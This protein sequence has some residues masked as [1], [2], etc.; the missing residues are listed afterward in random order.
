[1]KSRG[2]ATSLAQQRTLLANERT[3]LAYGRTTL[4]LFAFAV[5]YPRIRTAPYVSFL[6]TTS[7][8]LGVVLLFFGLYRFYVIRQQVLHASSLV[9]WKKCNG[10]HSLLLL[11]RKR[12][13][14]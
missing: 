14:Q 9:S 6:S 10:A 11:L 7:F 2:V 13:F 1:M 3:L 5:L 4:G 12:K 8:I